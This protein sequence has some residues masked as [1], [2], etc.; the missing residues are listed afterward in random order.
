MQS[1]DQKASGRRTQP[2]SREVEGRES[3]KA[4]SQTVRGADLTCA[5]PAD[6]HS[7]LETLMY[8]KGRKG[9]GGLLT[10]AQ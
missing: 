8:A 9:G 2:V 1:A 3:A 10:Q 5:T 4:A 7:A 6:E